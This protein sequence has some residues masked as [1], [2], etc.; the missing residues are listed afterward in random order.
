MEVLRKESTQALV[1]ESHVASSAS[2]I[3]RKAFGEVV[4]EKK[5]GWGQEARV[6]VTNLLQRAT[7]PRLSA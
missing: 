5:G 6:L 2:F 7:Y 3:E 1:N 4:P